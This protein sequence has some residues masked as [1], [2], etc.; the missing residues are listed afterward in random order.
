MSIIPVLATQFYEAY[1]TFIVY[2]IIPLIVANYK[3]TSNVY[4]AIYYLLIAVSVYSLAQMIG[5]QFWFYMSK[6]LSIK[7]MLTLE[8]LFC[9][10][11]YILFGFCTNIYMFVGSRFLM[12]VFS[13]NMAITQKYIIDINNENERNFYTSLCSGFTEIGRI[14]GFVVGAYFYGKNII[15]FPLMAISIV[16][17]GLSFILFIIVRCFIDVPITITMTVQNVTMPRYII[18]TIR[19]RPREPINNIELNRSLEIDENVNICSV[20]NNIKYRYLIA[21]SGFLSALFYG[22]SEILKLAMLS[23]VIKHGFGYNTQNVTIV[24]TISICVA[25]GISYIFF[26]FCKVIRRNLVYSV[27]TLGLITI[28][29]VPFIPRIVNNLSGMVALTIC[30]NIVCICFYIMDTIIM[31]LTNKIQNSSEIG[32]IYSISKNVSQIGGIMIMIPSLII[33]KETIQNPKINFI[34]DINTAFYLIAVL[35]FVPI[36]TLLKYVH[37]SQK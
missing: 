32:L 35:F 5:F 36:Y 26:Y 33:F 12:G 1:N 7:S 23:T 13:S 3:N 4:G 27:S 31:S 18:S 21:T 11:I 28:S 22:Y 37:L 16:S 2:I 9:G 25:L 6:Y 8:V 10:M 19:E 20:I 30:H 14:S 34:I 29:C 15:K 17:V 24:N